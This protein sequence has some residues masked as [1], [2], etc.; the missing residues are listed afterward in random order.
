MYDQI[1]D[2]LVDSGLAK[3]REV[4]AWMD[5]GGNIVQ[6]KSVFG[7]KVTHNIDTPDLVL[8]M[9]EVGGNKNQKEDS[10]VGCELQMCKRG[11]KP[12]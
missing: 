11:K 7:C 2:K 5:I 12:Q 8:I 6:E 4:T 9:D 1:G 3:E 10:N